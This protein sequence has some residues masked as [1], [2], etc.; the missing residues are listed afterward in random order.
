V[1]ILRATGNAI[2]PQLA[3]AFIAA[4]M[5]TSHENARHLATAGAP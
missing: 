5:E 1:D 3:A 2:V 4:V